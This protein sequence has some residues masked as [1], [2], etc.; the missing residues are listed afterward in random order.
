MC[1]SEAPGL[2]LDAEEG[3]DPLQLAAAVLSA[4]ATFHVVRGDEQLGGGALQPADERPIGVDHHALGRC[5]G[6]GGYR[7]RQALDLD[8]AQA[9]AGVRPDAAN[10]TEVGDI[11]AGIQGGEE[12]FFALFGLDRDAVNCQI[13]RFHFYPVVSARM[14]A[15]GSAATA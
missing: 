13:Y 8:E 3:G 4:G 9:A 1:R 15:A 11:D 7:R 12:D 2:Q 5:L 14:E 10:S 6:A